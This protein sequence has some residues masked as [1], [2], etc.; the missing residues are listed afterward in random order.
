MRSGYLGAGEGV[1]GEGEMGECGTR[2]E[3]EGGAL[4]YLLHCIEEAHSF[5]VV[6]ALIPVLYYLP[7]AAFFPLSRYF[8]PVSLFLSPLAVFYPL[9]SFLSSFFLFS[10][11]LSFFSYP[12]F[13]LLF[14]RPSCVLL[15]CSPHTLSSRT[16]IPSPP[17]PSPTCS[18]LDPSSYPLYLAPLS[19]IN[20]RSCLT[21]LPHTLRK[22][23]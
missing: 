20:Y 5:S 14:L 17:W 19:E 12:S 9:S 1:A 4:Y 22:G 7:L 3:E 21:K 8:S 18:L 16:H 10:L 2:E 13:P 11:I 23:E 15:M 6:S